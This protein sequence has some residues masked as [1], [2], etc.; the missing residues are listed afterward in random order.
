MGRI[1]QIC[2]AFIV[3]ART[4]AVLVFAGWLLIR[5]L[6]MYEWEMMLTWN[7][8]AFL[9]F[10]GYGMFIMLPI[11]NIP[12]SAFVCAIA[13]GVLLAVGS[14][15]VSRLLYQGWIEDDFGGAIQFRILAW[16]VLIPIYA[17]IPLAIMHRKRMTVFKTHALNSQQDGAANGSQPIRSETNRTSSAAGSRR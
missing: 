1:D 15:P 3:A 13:A 11:S 6:D 5:L 4:A 14:I 8:R 12:R 10:L 2:Q 7:A 9:A 16:S 17:Y